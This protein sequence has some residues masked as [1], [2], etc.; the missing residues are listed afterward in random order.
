MIEPL[1][2]HFVSR[3]ALRPRQLATPA[4]TTKWYLRMLPVINSIYVVIVMISSCFSWVSG[5]TA[6]STCSPSPQERG[7]ISRRAVRETFKGH[8]L[9]FEVTFGDFKMGLRFS[10][11]PFGGRNSLVGRSLLPLAALP[12]S[13]RPA[14]GSMLSRSPVR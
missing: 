9:G 6:A 12:L 2:R 11:S 8:F 13:A 3:K 7:G 14:I 10:E 5:R 1:R 4:G